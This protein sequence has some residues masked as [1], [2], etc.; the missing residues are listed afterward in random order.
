VARRI[1][2]IDVLRR[3]CPSD[4]DMSAHVPTGLKS[5]VLESCYIA[6]LTVVSETERRPLRR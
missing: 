3:D 6:E 5:N 4:A 2:S 1:S